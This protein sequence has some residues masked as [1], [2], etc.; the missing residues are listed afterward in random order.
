MKGG[1]VTT[2]TYHGATLRY[3]DHPY[4]TTR[5]N[6]RAVELPIAFRWLSRRKG[7]GL[8]FGNVLGHYRDGLDHRVV[9]LYERAPGVDNVDVFDVTDTYDWI[10]S[11]STIEHVR[12]DLDRRHRRDPFGGVL[13]LRHLESLLNPGGRMLVTVPLGCNPKLDAVIMA[14]DTGAKRAATLVRDGDGWVQTDDIV[15]K[16]YGATTPWAE[17]VW[18][19]EWT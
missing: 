17:S 4:N 5:A 10:V 11:V 9:D 13:A 8:E 16:P 1:R 12:W 14:G 6:E 19:G 2:F 7:D 3:Y 18:V 15:W